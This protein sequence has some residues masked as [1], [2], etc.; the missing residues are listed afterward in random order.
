MFL[1]FFSLYVRVVTLPQSCCPNI[2]VLHAGTHKYTSVHHVF[3]GVR[4]G[5]MQQS[6][7]LMNNKQNAISLPRSCHF[8]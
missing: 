6:Q 5:Q 8:T 3:P 2:P 7:K 4:V 1:T